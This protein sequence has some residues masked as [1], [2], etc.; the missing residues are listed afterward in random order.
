MAYNV[1][2][3]PMFKRG[4]T[5]A[6]GAGI[7]SHVEPKPAPRIRAANGFPTFGIT[8]APINPETGMTAYE[9]MLAK[10]TGPKF[11]EPRSIPY[12]QGGGFNYMLPSNMTPAQ[13]QMNIKTPT[14]K[15]N[16]QGVN[17]DQ[18]TIGLDEYD[19]TTEYEQIPKK[20]MGKFRQ[21]LPEI[22]QMRPKGTALDKK[23]IE[24]L[25]ASEDQEGDIFSGLETDVSKIETD[26][27]KKKLQPTDKGK[28]G[29]KTK[30]QEIKDEADFIRGLLKDEN[31]TRGETALILAEALATP[32]G[33][34]KKLDKARSLALPLIRERSK[35]D[36]AVTMQAYKA[37]K[38]KEQQ[39]IKAGALPNTLKEIRAQAEAEKTGGD[40]RSIEDIYSQLLRDS[41]AVPYETKARVDKYRTDK[42]DISS[43]V[44][45]LTSYKKQL[46]RLDPIKDKKTYDRI[47]GMYDEKYSQFYRDYLSEPEFKIL[48]RGIYDEFV[49]KKN[50]GRVMKAEG[51]DAEV[52]S[53][54][55][56]SEIETGGVETPIKTVQKLD[57]ATLRD[58]L[59]K[60]ITDQVVQL[61]AS[62]EEALQ[63]FSYITNQSDVDKFNVKYGVNLIIPPAQPTA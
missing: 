2:K 62:S 29:P 48:Y 12:I 4:G 55:V 21:N 43:N 52:E 30:E 44:N 35:E 24:T 7:M 6:Q 63:D 22:F 23:G 61:L 31:V 14:P 13:R 40:P 39:Q 8:Q 60:E 36:K 5:P 19:S 54:I 47:K 9:E 10:Q 16:I 20:E 45:T 41:I 27:D 1:F 32:G 59:P 38:E 56:T 57:Y 34:N 50:G 53:D 26:R 46:S 49:G 28:E 25:I 18:F 51:G 33:I 42:S 15:E 3:R 37:Y 58:R 17:E 11:A